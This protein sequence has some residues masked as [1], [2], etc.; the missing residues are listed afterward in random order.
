M[1]KA[2]DEDPTIYQYDEVFDEMKQTEEQG[3]AVKKEAKKTSKYIENL[4]KTADRR[5]REQEH[6]IERMVQKEREAE[7]AMFADKESFVTS[8]YKAKLEELKKMEEEE[9]NMDRLEAIGDVTKQPD[10]GGFYRHFFHQTVD[11]AKPA[12]TE[13]ETTTNNVPKIHDNS[14]ENDEKSDVDRDD[15]GPSTS[16]S[17]RSSDSANES[18]SRKARSRKIAAR[19]QRGRQYRQRVVEASESESEADETNDDRAEA[20]KAEV[21]IDEKHPN[22]E[23]SEPARKKIKASENDDKSARSDNIVIP[24]KP[25]DSPKKST[26]DGTAAPENNKGVDENT[27]AH[28]RAEEKETKVKVSIWEKRT[29]GPVFEA[30]LQRYYARK[31]NRLSGS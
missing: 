17:E 26:L 11:P 25:K 5:K 21:P 16:G 18:R 1:Q 12:E 20:T 4:L 15:V 9:Q 30:A 13:A 14:R 10:M 19:G 31:A 22:E 24:D 27:E 3:K 8:A 6:R 7:G 28:D 23:N 29:V 2:L